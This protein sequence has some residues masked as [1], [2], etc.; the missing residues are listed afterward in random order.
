MTIST[1]KQVCDSAIR[2]GGI[3]WPV[4]QPK[5][6]CKVC[7]CTEDR[8][9]PEGCSWVISPAEGQGYGLCDICLERVQIL[10]ETPRKDFK[11]TLSATILRNGHTNV[12]ALALHNARGDWRRAAIAKE[13][14]RRK[15]LA[16]E[17]QRA[18][19]KP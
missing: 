19:R 4:Q 10:L 15:K 7:G 14:E 3:A 2:Y 16:A 9:C 11:K 17:P 8:A 12:L 5:G 18:K 13:L 1:G 6:S